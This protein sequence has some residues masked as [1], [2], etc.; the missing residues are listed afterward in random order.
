MV[1][2]SPRPSPPK[3]GLLGGSIGSRN[4]GLAGLL[5]LQIASGRSRLTSCVIRRI[6]ARPCV[7]AGLDSPRRSVAHHRSGG[8]DV[9]NLQVGRGRRIGALR[10]RASPD[11]ERASGRKG[12]GH[13]QRCAGHVE[14]EKDRLRERE[15]QLRL[16]RL[17]RE[18]EELRAR[19]QAREYAQPEVV[20]TDVYVP[21]Y[22]YW[23]PRHGR[24][25]GHVKPRPE[26]PIAK[27]RPPQ[28]TQPIDE[29]SAVRTPTGA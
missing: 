29:L 5:V 1:G 20:Y 4:T 28:R 6:V 15:D 13:R 9:R 7:H 11:E 17:E 21:A 25:I 19:E 18:V 24:D 14:E 27:P 2:S 3:C 12:F 10:R 22:G 26:H 23:R 8:G 16:Q